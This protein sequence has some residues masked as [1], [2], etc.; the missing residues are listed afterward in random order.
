LIDEHWLVERAGGV[1]IEVLVVPR[2][3]RTQVAGV[4]DGRLKVQLNAPPVEGEA[5]QALIELLAERLGIKKSAVA[6]VSGQT[7]KR[8]RV[9][10]EGVGVA[11]VRS[12]APG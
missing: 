5:N 6:I 10:I 12:L 8:K 7:G 2:A 3:S 4:H 11:A 1:E 9:R